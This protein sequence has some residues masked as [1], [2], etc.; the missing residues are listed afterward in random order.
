MVCVGGGGDALPL[1][2]LLVPTYSCHVHVTC[3]TCPCHM[4]VMC[5]V[6]YSGNSMSH[7][8]HMSHSQASRALCLHVVCHSPEPWLENPSERRWD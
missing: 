6:M 3:L 1:H 4:Y 8:H 7:A 5:P 2:V